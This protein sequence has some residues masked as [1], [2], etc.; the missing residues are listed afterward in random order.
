M[1]ADRRAPTLPEVAISS[2][3]A[4]KKLALALVATLVALLAAELMV[5][6]LGAAPM[7]YAIQKGRFQLS[8]NPKIGYEPVPLTY[9]GRELS[10]YDYRGASNSLGYRDVEHAV[11]KAPGTYRIVV[12]GNSVAAGLGVDRFEDTFPP[13]LGELLKARGLQAEVINLGVSGYNPQQQVETLKD[14]GLQYQ[15]DLVLVAYTLTARQR[16]DGDIMKTLLAAEEAKGGV[17]TARFDSVLVDSALYRLLRFRVLAPKVAPRQARADA[18]RHLAVVSGDTVAPSFDEL[19]ALQRAHGF[20]VLV[21]VFPRLVRNFR[22]YRFAGDHRFVHQ[23][24]EQH[25]FRLLDLLDVFD[26]CRSSG[27]A[28][29]DFDVYHPSAHGHRC[30]AEA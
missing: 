25:G 29:I 30:A 6:L 13:I 2:P 19:A 9:Q 11:A 26:R 12:L 10:F 3:S 8:H 20:D 1:D 21:A 27:G 15:P 16:L 22:A 14:R 5:R 24:A 17:S 7:I 28:P 4:S 23:L 18:E